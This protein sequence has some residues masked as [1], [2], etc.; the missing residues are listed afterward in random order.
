MS[1]T[2]DEPLSPAA[3]V[4]L[5]ESFQRNWEAGVAVVYGAFAVDGG[6]GAGGPVVDGAVVGGC[7]FNGGA[8]ASVLELGYWVHVDHL[9]RGY[10]S[11]MATALTDAAF[12]Q[13]GIDRVEIHHDRANTRSGAVP[14]RLGFTFEGERPD[15][16][17]APGEDGIDC[18]WTMLRSDWLSRRE[19]RR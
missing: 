12:A 14:A 9:R 1:W 11:E 4:A 15:E 6:D 3:R 18:R 13:A 7:G 10:A 19:R 17:M 5:L 2:A 16:V 8:E